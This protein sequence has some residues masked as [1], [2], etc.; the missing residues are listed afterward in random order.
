MH[1]MTISCH[2]IDFRGQSDWG[3]GEG[4][5]IVEMSKLQIMPSVSYF[6]RLSCLF[7][8]IMVEVTIEPG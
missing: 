2:A 1:R 5:C 6:K 7:V 8:S 4:G 3:G